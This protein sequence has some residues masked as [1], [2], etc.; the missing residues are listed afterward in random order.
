WQFTSNSKDYSRQHNTVFSY[1]F[2]G[3]YDIIYEFVDENGC[4]IE[5]TLNHKVEAETPTLIIEGDIE[6]CIPVEVKYTSTI[7]GSKYPATSYKWFIDDEL[8][9]TEK[10]YTHYYATAG[11]GVIKLIVENQF[12]CIYESFEIY[13]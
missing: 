10:E 1:E 3:T 8:V 12:G 2:P 9:S 4:I 11:E 13:S 5:G 6:G 7:E